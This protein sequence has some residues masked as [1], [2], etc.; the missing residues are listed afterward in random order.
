M[1]LYQKWNAHTKQETALEWQKENIYLN[2]I[3]E[4]LKTKLNGNI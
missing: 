3:I 1:S 2:W 4:L